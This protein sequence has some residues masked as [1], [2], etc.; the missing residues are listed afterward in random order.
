MSYF[1]IM[2]PQTQCGGPVSYFRA[3][4][5][6]HKA[7]AW[8]LTFKP[9]F[10]T[11]GEKAWCLNISTDSPAHKVDP[12]HFLLCDETMVDFRFNLDIIIQWQI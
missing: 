6:T 8:H 3:L 9:C 11:H 10:T 5:P 2:I 1:H 7:E 12:L 4:I